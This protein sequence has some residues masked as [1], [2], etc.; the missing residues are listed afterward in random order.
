MFP[1]D[2]KMIKVVS[3]RHF[4][5]WLFKISITFMRYYLFKRYMGL[6]IFL[7]KKIKIEYKNE[8]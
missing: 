4:N 6:I 1:F 2:K 3:E 7:K 8:E 5:E